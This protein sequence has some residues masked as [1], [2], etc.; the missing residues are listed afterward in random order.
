MAYDSLV[1][2]P[3][4][5]CR[6]CLNER[7]QTFIDI[8]APNEPLLAQFVKE[9]YKVEVTGN[10][11]KSTKLCQRCMENIDVWRGHIDQAKSCQM[12]VNF[13]AEKNKE[14]SLFISNK[15]KKTVSKKSK[16][17]KRFSL[18]TEHEIQFTSASYD[19]I[20]PSTES[21]QQSTEST[22]AP[23]HQIPSMGNIKSI[24]YESNSPSIS[25]S[26]E[27]IPF[28]PSSTAMI[29]FISGSTEIV[30]YLSNS[31]ANNPSLEIG[32]M[33]YSIINE[34]MNYVS[35][36]ETFTRSKSLKAECICLFC[37]YQYED[38]SLN[39]FKNIL[40]CSNHSIPYACLV[41]NCYKV[42]PIE[43]L[44]I[45]HYLSHMK[46]DRS[47]SL[48]SECFG[49]LTSKNTHIHQNLFKCC[50][51]DF[52]SMLK[53]GLHKI[54][55][56]NA[57]VITG[58]NQQHPLKKLI[59][60]SKK[61]KTELLN[62]KDSDLDV[63]KKTR[64]N[65]VRL[66]VKEENRGSFKC[67]RCSQYLN[68]V[69]EYTE[70]CQ[71]KH[72]DII[73][74]REPGIKLCPLCDHCYFFDQFVSHIESC[75]NTLKVGDKSLNH[76]GCI[77]CK[78]VFTNLSSRQIRNHVLYC[79]SFQ[80]VV[81]NNKLFQKCQNCT[82]L[83]VDDNLC[84]AHANSDCIYLQLKMRYAIKPDEKADAL[85]RMKFYEA[86]TQQQENTNC[87]NDEDS[88]MIP[89]TSK[90]VCNIARQNLLKSYN[91]L[92]NVC[93]N[94]FFDKDIFLKHLT[95]QGVLCRLTTL[96][97]C[98]RCVTDFETE[99]EYQDHV[100]KIPDASPLISIKQ[101]LFDQN[102]DED[103]V[104][105]DIVTRADQ[106][107]SYDV[108]VFEMNNSRQASN[109]GIL[110]NIQYQEQDN[111]LASQ[112]M[113]FNANDEYMQCDVEDKPDLNQLL[114]ENM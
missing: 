108:K 26:T 66:K 59:T 111:S 6:I 77:H 74:L 19:M 8:L 36:S 21:V 4:A 63:P 37:T 76:Y 7:P 78:F 14:R 109:V 101:E 73:L 84:L 95:S 83:S 54:I 45:E 12:V 99:Q 42:F 28:L 24:Q 93:N 88:T 41:E 94:F 62:T 11:S 9:Y 80:L 3:L 23:L 10:D 106:N 29:P 112:E 51:L 1:I 2:T 25:I 61:F 65:E 96:V 85:R 17:R 71:N 22:S 90:T 48:C 67:S 82:F 103:V 92:C 46:L 86:N 75:T 97:Y 89:S 49:I 58:S 91:F 40:F 47:T 113:E 114:I 52:T 39:M 27:I 15:K 34:R 20:Q 87:A 30:P 32:P 110:N 35:P 107:D 104:M 79:K 100:P 43:E 60:P 38:V 64:R 53:F 13:L 72:N 5:M 57:V 33:Q 81:V 55:N 31:T 50:S 68:T 98:Q 16:K 56:H 18:M 70:H 102:N 69:S 44:F 105:Y